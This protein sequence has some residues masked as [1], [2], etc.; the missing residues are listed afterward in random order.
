MV[1]SKTYIANLCVLRIKKR[2]RNGWKGSE[3]KL[4]K[5]KKGYFFDKKQI[6]KK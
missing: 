2:Q 3:N 5:D 1:L 4:D 6:T